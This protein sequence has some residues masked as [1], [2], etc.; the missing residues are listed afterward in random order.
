MTIGIDARFY[1]DFGIGRVLVNLL[2]NLEKID[3]ET[4]YVVFLKEDN[5][6][7]YHPEQPNFKKVVAN[8]GWYS[9]SEQILLPRIFSREKLDLL[10]V[11]HLNI[12]VFYPGKMVVMIHD[13]IITEFKGQK[14]TLRNPLLYNFKHLSYQVVLNRA[15]RKAEKIIVPSLV[16]K[17]K[18]IGKFSLPED[19][20]AVIA[21]AADE[22]FGDKL[23]QEEKA[24]VR[25]RYHVNDFILAVGNNSPHKNLE[26]L[27]EVAGSLKGVKIVLVSPENEFLRRLKRQA[28]DNGVLEK[29]VFTGRVGDSDLKDL[30]QTATA[31]VFP[32][33]EE[34]FGLPGLEAMSVGLPVL[35]SDIP[36]FKEVYGEAAMYFDPQDKEDLITRINILLKEKEIREKYIRLGKDQVKKYSWEKFSRETRKVLL[37]VLAEEKTTS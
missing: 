14:A 6:D 25:E 24:S 33:F 21:E 8:V 29:I 20:I 37:D 12:P 17:E 10:F 7:Q 32:S 23:T 36:V 13:L 1:G 15:V 34:G 27:V 3:S 35:V 4:N 9:I 5:F 11:P 22:T 18:L 16:V 26:L 31:F 2:R 19:R 28:I 30:Y